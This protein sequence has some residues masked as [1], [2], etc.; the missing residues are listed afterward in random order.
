[1]MAALRLADR[2]EIELDEAQRRVDGGR[3]AGGEED[4]AEITRGIEGQAA[5]ELDA[6]RRGDR[7]ERREVVEPAS[8]VGDRLRHLLPPMAD[9]DAPQAADAVEQALAVGVDDMHAL[10]RDDHHRLGRSAGAEA[11]PGMDEM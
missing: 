3:A 5:G 6:R 8:L 1:D 9:I 11:L 7:A 2:V 4:M 10:G